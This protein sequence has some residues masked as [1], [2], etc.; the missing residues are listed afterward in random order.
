MIDLSKEKKLRKLVKEDLEMWRLMCTSLITAPTFIDKWPPSA[1]CRNVF[2]HRDWMFA[3]VVGSAMLFCF[4]RLKNLLS[5]VDKQLHAFDKAE[6]T[7]IH[8]KVCLVC[9]MQEF[10]ACDKSIGHEERLKVAFTAIESEHIRYA[11]IWLFCNKFIQKLTTQRDNKLL[12]EG[13][14][15]LFDNFYNMIS[16]SKAIDFAERITE[17]E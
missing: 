2:E 14:Q 4:E 13:T 16:T 8:E 17:G 9:D 15:Y 1:M 3:A 11:I 6:K 5:E 12:S 10:I 7:N